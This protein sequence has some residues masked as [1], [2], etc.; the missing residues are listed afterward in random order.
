MTDQ[1]DWEHGFEVLTA[2]TIKGTIFSYMKM[3]CR[4]VE[5][6]WR[7]GGRYCLRI[8]PRRVSQANSKQ[9][10]IINVTFFLFGSKVLDVNNTL[11]VITNSYRLLGQLFDPEDGRNTFPLNVCEGLLDDTGSYSRRHCSSIM[12]RSSDTDKLSLWNCV[13]PRIYL[14][15]HIPYV[16]TEGL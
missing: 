14:E 6:H 1:K 3:P 15:C 8:Q 13:L 9:K 2:G 12:A 4:W 5:V 11:I 10:K 16:E 7:S